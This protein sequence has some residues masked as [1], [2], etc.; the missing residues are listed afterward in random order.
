MRDRIATGLTLLLGG[1]IIVVGTGY[2]LGRHGMTDGFGVPGWASV[3]QPAYEVKG[4]RD[5]ASG[6]VP[7]TLLA[8]GR[9]REL[10]Y[11]LAAEALIPLG[12]MRTV[13]R[14]GGPR[15][16]ALGVHGATAAAMAVTAALLLRR[17]R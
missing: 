15:S 1:G 9:R 10:G 14:H 13:L 11:A 16:V 17:P 12:D 8:L 6:L 4:V 7:L 5:I 3:P 2:R